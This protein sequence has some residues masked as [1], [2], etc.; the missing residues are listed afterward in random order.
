MPTSASAGAPTAA[1]FGSEASF[2]TVESAW[3]SRVMQS[4]LKVIRQLR[5]AGEQERL[6][7]RQFADRRHAEHLARQMAG[8]RDVGGY[9]G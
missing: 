7:R 5:V 6:V 2:R 4:V 9:L 3:R 1:S 8:L